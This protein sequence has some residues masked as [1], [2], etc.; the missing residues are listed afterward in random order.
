MNTFYFIRHAEPDHS[1]KEDSTRPLSKEGI[2]DRKLLIEYFKNKKVDMFYSSP[3]KRAFDTVKVIA[4]YF[5]LNV[6][7][8]ERFKERCAGNNSNNKE[9]FNRRWEDFNFAE[10]NG[11]SIGNV[12]KRNIE[13]LNEINKNN[14]GK[15][16]VIGTH[17][18]ALSSILN[19]YDNTFN[20]TEFLRIINYMPF[21]VKVELEN[22]QCI[23]VNEEYFLEKEYKK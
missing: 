21:I 2:E 6:F 4:D 13:A 20:C 22:N 3:Y 15:T 16:I 18:P 19:Y 9:M 10:N 7:I 14:D 5:N 23:C 11:E 1:W 8:D 17:G 12:Q